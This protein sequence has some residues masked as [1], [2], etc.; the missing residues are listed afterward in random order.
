MIC[1]T[2]LANNLP[3][4][5]FVDDKSPIVLMT[6][7]SDY[8]IG[9]Y[10]YQLIGGIKYPIAFVSKALSEREQRW[11]TREKE[12]WAIVF[13]LKKLEYLLRDRKFTLQTDHKNLIYM[14][15]ETDSKVARWKMFI[16]RYDCMIEHIAGVK[17]PVADGFSRLLPM[18]EEELQLRYEFNIPEEE[19]KKIEAVH[20]SAVGHH[21]EHRT[22]KKL[23]AQ[24][25]NW[26]YM[27][28]HVRKF[29]KQCAFCQKMSYL[30][31]PIHTHPF[32]VACY[33]PMERLGM[34]SIGPLEESADG[35]CYI[36]VIIC[37]FTRW[38]ELYALKD[39]TME[40]TARVLRQHFGRFGRPSQILTDGGSQFVNGTIE[41]L[42]EMM[43][44]Q[45]ITTLA[46]SKEENSLVERANKEVMRHTRALVYESNMTEEWPDDLPTAQTIMNSS[47]VESISCS[48]AQ[49]LFGNAITLERSLYLAREEIP[50]DRRM[51]LSQWASNRLQ[52]QED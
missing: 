22:I 17:N 47:E 28:N 2:L 19:Y 11:D 52:A 9:A 51:F 45:Q 15:T 48:P 21:G 26:K 6:D 46:Y 35:Y 18:T 30:R 40:T 27:R 4:L 31:V 14:N 34:D 36:L 29:L 24:G 38:V 5:F 50:E 20:N 23:I 39:L 3:T 1:A 7:A 37:C 12:C 42:M 13:A 41:E 32:T 43:G 8:G 16:S 33:Q 10:C 44:T 49:L 25:H